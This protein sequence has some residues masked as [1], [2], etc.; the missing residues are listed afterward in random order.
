MWWD[1]ESVECCEKGLWVYF[2]KCF[3]PIQQDGVKG[4][5]RGFGS[6]DESAYDVH[7]LRG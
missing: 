1:T 3:F 6:L 5:S 2:V 7:G 4:L